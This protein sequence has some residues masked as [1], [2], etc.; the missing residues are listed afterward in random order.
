MF[1]NWKDVWIHIVSY[2]FPDIVS[3][4]LKYHQDFIKNE[5]NY[6]NTSNAQQNLCKEMIDMIFTDEIIS[7]YHTWQGT[8][9]AWLGLITWA[10]TVVL[11]LQCCRPWILNISFE[12]KFIDTTLCLFPPQGARFRGMPCIISQF[13]KFSLSILHTE[14]FMLWGHIFF[15]FWSYW[16]LM[17]F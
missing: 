9:P 6:I 12:H 3:L 2:I 11:K 17:V 1:I 8:I 5:P 16:Q 7:V 14:S 4:H 15:I 10:L 13:L